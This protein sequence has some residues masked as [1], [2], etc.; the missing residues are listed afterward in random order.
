MQGSK[1]KQWTKK[2]FPWCETPKEAAKMVA[3]YLKTTAESIKVKKSE[4]ESPEQ[5]AD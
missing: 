3:E 4:W 5:S 2:Y 1:D